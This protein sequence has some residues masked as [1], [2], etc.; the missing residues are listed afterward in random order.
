MPYKIG[1]KAHDDAIALA[2]SVH[3]ASLKSA[4]TQAAA[5]ASD[6]TY[7]RAVA[8]SSRLNNGSTDIAAALTAL[9]GAWC[10]TMSGLLQSLPPESE[11]NRFIAH[12]ADAE[13]VRRRMIDVAAVAADAA[14]A[15]AEA[16]KEIAAAAAIRSKHEADVKNAADSMERA[17]AH[18][19][20]AEALEQK[21]SQREKTHTAAAAS[22]AQR[23]AE[24][25]RQHRQRD[26]ELSAR[27]HALTERGRAVV[28]QEERVAFMQAGLEAKL[29][30]V[31]G[32]AA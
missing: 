4:T 12:L 20:A 15:Q 21:L 2:E 6:I 10:V 25:Q 18:M 5:T 19:R 1:V 17:I 31:R 23:M 29:R 24:T 16:A 9:H 32:L 30:R 3:Q 22:F 13:I 11:L 27:E 8:A 26:V 14:A 7:F 28:A